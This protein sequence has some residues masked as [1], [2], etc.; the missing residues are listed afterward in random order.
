MR[1]GNANRKF[2]RERDQRQA[3]IR[4]LIVSMIDHGKITTTEEKAK[5][6]RPFVEKLLTHAKKDTVA[7]RRLVMSRVNS[8]KTVTKLFTLAKEK[9][10]ERA[11]GYTRIVKMHDKRGVTGGKAI[12]EFV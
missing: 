5:E 6:I 12:I 8:A 1:H 7:S 4:S 10:L 11:G 9:Y 3:L 2:G